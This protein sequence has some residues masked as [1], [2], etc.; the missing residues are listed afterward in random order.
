MDT[1]Y[2]KWNVAYVRHVM[3]HFGCYKKQDYALQACYQYKLMLLH[4]MY[5]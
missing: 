3:M 5:S 1:H 2:I 4:T